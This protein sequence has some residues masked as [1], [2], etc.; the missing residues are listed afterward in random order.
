LRVQ[1]NHLLCAGSLSPIRFAIFPAG[2]PVK[3]DA[4]MVG[5]AGAVTV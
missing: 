1:R 5:I 2:I 3:S 4:V